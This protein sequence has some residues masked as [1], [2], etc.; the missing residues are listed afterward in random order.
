MKE[1]REEKT[2]GRK[3]GKIDGREGRKERRRK[4]GRIGPLGS[5]HCFPVAVD[6]H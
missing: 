4:L 6:L 1:G 5:F 3:E 2:D